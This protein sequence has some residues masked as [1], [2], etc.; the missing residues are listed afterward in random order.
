MGYEGHTLTPSSIL[1]QDLLQP[2]LGFRP[3]FDE[4]S[5]CLLGSILSVKIIFSCVS[6]E[7]NVLPSVR[8]RLFWR[9]LLIPY[10]LYKNNDPPD[11][12]NNGHVHIVL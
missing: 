3:P 12:E 8:F 10:E 9:R 7:P 11:S 1:L 2:D 6:E 5:R 4:P